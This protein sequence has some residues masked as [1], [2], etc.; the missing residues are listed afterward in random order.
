M[1]YKRSTDVGA[2][3]AD[4]TLG[5]KFSEGRTSTNAWCRDICDEDP[6]AR[7]V[8]ERLSNL[9]GIP[10]RNSE[11]LQLLRYEEGQF[12]NSHHDLIEAQV[13]MAAGPRILTVFI[14]LNNVEAGGG[15]HFEEL[16]LT[17][18]PKRGRVVIWPSVYDENPNEKD[19]STMHEAL[20]VEKGI[21]Y[22]ANAW[23]HLRDYMTPSDKGCM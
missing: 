7:R 19:W 8:Y 23:Y 3:Q 18:M 11:R 22:G 4:G 10:E 14:Y 17:V 16:D 2:R 1:G 5:K 12:Y 21:K 9:T 13:A 6:I 20:K 15:T